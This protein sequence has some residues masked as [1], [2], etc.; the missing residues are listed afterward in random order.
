MSA[1]ETIENA[2]LAK[3]VA[4]I[5]TVTTQRGAKAI[6][7]IPVT[8]LPYAFTASPAISSEAVD[9]E[10]RV[11][12]TGINVVIVWKRPA[13]AS[14]AGSLRAEALTDIE[15]IE[16]AIEETDPTLAA[17]VKAARV[18]SFFL[19][20]NPESNVYVGV[21]GIVVEERR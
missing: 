5:A 19:D 21:L 17:T 18:E 11:R 2:L 3:V 14:G 1:I 20:E 9:F 15:A 16:T 8:S 12:R 13:D 6:E 10:Q 4:Q 7:D